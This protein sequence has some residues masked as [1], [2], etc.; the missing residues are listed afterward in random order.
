MLIIQGQVDPASKIFLTLAEKMIDKAMKDKTLFSNKEH[1]FVYFHLLEI[2]ENLE[3]PVHFL[4]ETGSEKYFSL[5]YDH[6]QFLRRAISKNGISSPEVAK[7]MLKLSRR[8][9]MDRYRLGP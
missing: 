3:K 6:N 9:L 8:I 4:E 1:V 2:T 5:P 7:T